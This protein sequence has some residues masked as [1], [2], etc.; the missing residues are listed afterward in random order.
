MG[1]RPAIA[2]EGSS[3]LAGIRMLRRRLDHFGMIWH[4]DLAMFWTCC[5]DRA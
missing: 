5:R 3:A 4:D 1:T 2:I